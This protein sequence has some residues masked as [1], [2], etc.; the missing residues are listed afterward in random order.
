MASL[1][2]YAVPMM[3]NKEAM[4]AK[5]KALMKDQRDFLDC[6]I[7][8]RKSAGISQEEVAER[9]GVSHSVVSQFE[10]YDADPTLSVLRR[11]ALAVGASISYK[12]V[13]SGNIMS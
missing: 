4:K 11:Y 5:A 12:A 9:M 7:D 1:V 3:N 8:I 2:I 6:L 13:P 10:H